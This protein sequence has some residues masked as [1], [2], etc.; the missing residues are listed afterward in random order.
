MNG[1]ASKCSTFITYGYGIIRLLRRYLCDFMPSGAKAKKATDTYGIRMMY[2]V[3]EKSIALS[4]LSFAG[5]KVAC[6]RVLHD[7]SFDPRTCLIDG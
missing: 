1:N 7:E 4:N 2:I 5:R 3:S 6:I